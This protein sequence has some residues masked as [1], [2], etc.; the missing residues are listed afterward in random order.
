MDRRRF[1]RCL[2]VFIA[3]V[4]LTSVALMF[5]LVPPVTLP[6]SST[7]NSWALQQQIN[8]TPLSLDTT[9]FSSSVTPTSIPSLLF[10]NDFTQL[11]DLKTFH[12]LKNVP[13][14]CNQSNHLLVII[15]SAPQNIEKR[16]AIR[17]TW[18]AKS[19]NFS[20]VIF[21]LGYTSDLKIQKI[22]DEE[23][24][25]Y[26]D[27]VQGNFIDKYRN[28]TYKHV[29]AL[30]WIY[31]YCNSD[32]KYILKSDDDVFINMPNLISFIPTLPTSKLI[33]CDVIY[34]AR[35]KRTW[36]S[37]WRVSY[38]EYASR[39][40][41]NYCAGWAILYSRDMIHRLYSESQKHP[42][43]WVDDVLLTGILAKKLKIKHFAA[44]NW[45]L[46]EEESKY[47]ISKKQWPNST[48]F[49]GP[50]DTSPQNI[51]LLW[52]ILLQT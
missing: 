7:S 39:T 3:S 48:L 30:K 25:K 16:S 17:D 47:V 24:S 26:N 18:G 32:I 13:S 21:M 8:D 1:I 10:P 45:I 9:S 35:V 40:Y 46:K 38:K 11:I 49:L 51:R 2:R 52:K 4:A 29:M 23:Q 41:P 22:L 20:N 14:A 27:I 15:H 37:K 44:A 12:F 34:N 5:L 50:Y 42:F 31:Y 43:F 19:N 33:F 28:I 6:S 36:R